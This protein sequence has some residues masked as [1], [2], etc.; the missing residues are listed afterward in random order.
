MAWVFLLAIG[1]VTAV[2]FRTG[3]FWVHYSDG[4]N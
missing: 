3:K 2:V 4:E 1:L